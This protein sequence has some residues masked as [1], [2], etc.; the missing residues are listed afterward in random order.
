MTVR[1]SLKEGDEVKEDD[2][3]PHNVKLLTDLELPV[4]V[5]FRFKTEVP[6]I[7]SPPKI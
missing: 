3:F 2:E 5:W 4:F 7:T 6:L 1:S